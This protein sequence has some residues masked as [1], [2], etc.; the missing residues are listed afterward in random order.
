ML[1]QRFGAVGFAPGTALLFGDDSAG[2][3][4]ALAAIE[5][6]G[7]RCKIVDQIASAHLALEDEVAEIL[8]LEVGS[9]PLQ[10]LESLLTR[11]DAYAAETG[12]PIIVSAP[13][14]E[15]DH[16]ASYLWPGSVE[17]LCEPSREDRRS[18]IELALARRAAGALY[19]SNAARRDELERLRRDVLQIVKR[20]DSL[21]SDA[22][23][24]AERVVAQDM[25]K[26]SRAEEVKVRIRA[27]R[28]RD[29]Y[30][31]PRLFADPAWDILL[32][33]YSAH[34]ERRDVSVSSLCIAAATPPTTA[35][36]WIATMT[37]ADLLVRQ[38]H[39][40]DRRR[41]NISLSKRALDAIDRYFEALAS[42]RAGVSG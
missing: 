31:D 35:L 32:D 11:I 37:D 38:P 10:P 24:P 27:R 25:P 12:T 23:L 13:L 34:L 36:R 29:K 20:V 18:A 26:R 40:S 8:V 21:A 7:L 39:E 22:S 17:L 19:D 33:L 42:G 5:Q 30:F 14:A 3:D 41:F 4:E 9:N 1:G 15:I 6:A 28:L 16:V 2:L